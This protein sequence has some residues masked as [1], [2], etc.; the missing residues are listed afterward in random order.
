M[1]KVTKELNSW[2]NDVIDSICTD[3]KSAL[4]TLHCKNQKQVLHTAI[5]FQAMRRSYVG[6]KCTKLDIY[7]HDKYEA[8]C[9]YVNK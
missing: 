1:V 3:N 9:E 6:Y 4:V 8:W 2:F 7:G 5:V